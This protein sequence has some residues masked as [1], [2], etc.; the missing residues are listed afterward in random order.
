MNDE[1]VPD[2]TGTL[3][4]PMLSESLIRHLPVQA[5][6]P[7]DESCPDDSSGCLLANQAIIRIQ[8]ES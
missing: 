3:R 6:L 7:S 8:Q 4:V 1:Q 5:A 2:N